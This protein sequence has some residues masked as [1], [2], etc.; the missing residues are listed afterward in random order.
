MVWLH[1]WRI[2]PVV[3]EAAK[4]NTYASYTRPLAAILAG[5]WAD[6]WQTSKLVTLLFFCG[7]GAFFVMSGDFAANLTTRV[8]IANLLI[9]FVAVYAL[10]GIYFSLIE[11]AKLDK[12]MTGSAV[13]LISVL[14]F[15][16]DIFFG[17]VTGRILDANPGALGFQN[18][19]LLLAAICAV[20]MVFTMLLARQIRGSGEA[21]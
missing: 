12:R 4:L 11:E 1:C 17:S 2:F 5:L 8:V 6:R 13:G 10:R 7:G 18:Y 3:P 15:T 9:T 21:T 16:P 19:F 14:G 20:G